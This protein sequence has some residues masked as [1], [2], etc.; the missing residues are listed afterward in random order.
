MIRN[1]KNN[2]EWIARKIC[3]HPEGYKVSSAVRSLC[4]KFRVKKGEAEHVLALIV[5]K[6]WADIKETSPY[7]INLMPTK[8]Y[9]KYMDENNIIPF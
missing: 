6:G 4:A 9:E 1:T 5:A 2:Q 3:W 7:D 8:K